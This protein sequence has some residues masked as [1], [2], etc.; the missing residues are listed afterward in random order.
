MKARS[1]VFVVTVLIS[2]MVSSGAWA[3]DGQEYSLSDLIKII[4]MVNKDLP[5]KLDG[6]VTIDRIVQGMGR[7]MI[8]IY[9]LSSKDVDLTDKERK[10]LRKSL[11]LIHI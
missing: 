1:I 11:S 4:N 10:E 9:D 5:K 8:Y 7:Q 6:G 2:L 3:E